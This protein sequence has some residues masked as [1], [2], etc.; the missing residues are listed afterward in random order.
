MSALRPAARHETVVRLDP[1]AEAEEQ[2]LALDEVH[3][4]EDFVTWA[5]DFGARLT[6][7]RPLDDP[8]AGPIKVTLAFG[9]DMPRDGII[10][11]A[12]HP[13]ALRQY[14]HSLLALAARATAAADPTSVPARSMQ[15]A[16]LAPAHAAQTW[17]RVVLDVPGAKP[18]P[19]GRWLM[20]LMPTPDD[21]LRHITIPAMYAATVED[22]SAP[23]PTET[24][25]HIVATVTR[26]QHTLRTVC[27]RLFGPA[28]GAVWRSAYPVDNEVAH[29]PEHLT[30]WQ[31]LDLD[32]PAGA[33]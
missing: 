5:L 19:D 30:D 4:P 24:G 8:D 32:R 33:A 3:G 18:T 11:R 26:G 9:P 1:A 21:A 13:G 7:D 16:E 27:A 14:A 20:L 31:V 15:L 25:T 22:R 17:K 12:V 28:D 6:F 2:G 10:Q 29:R 23:L